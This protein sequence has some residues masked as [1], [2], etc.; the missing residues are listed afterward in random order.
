[1]N[2]SPQSPKSGFAM[3]EVLISILVIAFGLLGL[4]GLQGFSIRNNHNAYLRS[5]A[6][7]FA[8]DITDRIRANRTGLNSGF[9]DSGTVATGT[10]ACQFSGS[11]AICSAAQL[12]A[13][14]LFV[15]QQMLSQLPGGLGVVCLDS[16]ANY[17]GTP[18]APACDGLGNPDTDQYVAKIWFEE[19][20]ALTQFNVTF[21][22]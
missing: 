2:Q 8:Y 4:A 7:L 15:W 20:G 3:L 16:D 18:T 1:M 5:Q 10:G 17:A 22:P 12:A 21:R 19:N 13:Y 14:D 6:T 11:P 9:Y